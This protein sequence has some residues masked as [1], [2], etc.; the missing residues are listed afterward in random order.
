M[1][2]PAI[3]FYP[4]DW[5]KDSDLS[6]C[7]PATRGIWMD[8]LCAMHQSDRSDSLSGTPE[9]LSRVLRC[10]CE[11]VNTAIDDLKT[12]GAAIVHVRNGVVTLISRRFQRE[13]RERLMNL[14]RVNKHRRN[15]KD[16][17]LK[18][19]SSSS[20]SSSASTN[21]PTPQG[22]TSSGGHLVAAS[23]NQRKQDRLEREF[24]EQK[25]RIK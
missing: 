3:Q 9:Q 8:A 5:L 11:D 13:N 10:T 4:G 7:L 2:V 22:G 15:G 24:K 25:A 6:K 17:H 12:T 14:E 21:P 18:C 23:K 19:P 16:I 20:T 1:K